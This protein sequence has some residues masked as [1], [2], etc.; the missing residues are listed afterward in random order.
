MQALGRKALSGYICVNAAFCSWNPGS[1][2][3]PCEV[4]ASL[5]LCC[6]HLWKKPAPNLPSSS[7]LSQPG[8]WLTTDRLPPG[9]H[10]ASCQEGAESPALTSPHLH[11]VSSLP[12][13][14]LSPCTPCPH[15]ALGEG[16]VLPQHFKYTEFVL[17]LS[18]RT[19]AEGCAERNVFQ[20]AFSRAHQSPTI[21]SP[22]NDYFGLW[23]LRSA[24]CLLAEERALNPGMPEE[25]KTRF[26]NGWERQ[27]AGA[28]QVRNQNSSFKRRQQPTA[29]GHIS[30]ALLLPA[31]PAP[32][33][34]LSS[35]HW[36]HR[37]S[38][39]HAAVGW[40][41]QHQGKNSAYKT[42]LGHAFYNLC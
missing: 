25:F 16:M 10:A 11:Q 26:C 18:A 23:L 40:D 4:R 3:L 31:V 14:A 27:G 5:G 35:A 34:Q 33:L 42:K 29:F 37:P 17:L 2:Q 36:Q 12:R 28:A 13:A 8:L 9:E 21:S 39:L 32:S 22:T 15:P 38:S 6:T 30:A 1:F 20:T 41:F 19:P 7:F 24:H